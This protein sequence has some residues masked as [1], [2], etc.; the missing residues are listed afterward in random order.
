M[1][2]L[3]KKFLYSAF[4][5][6]PSYKGAATHI[7]Q[8][9]L[10]NLDINQNGILTVLGNEKLPIYQNENNLEIYRFLS[11]E[12]NYLLRAQDFSKFV[13]NI[14][15]KNSEINYFH[16]R[17][18]WSGLG[19]FFSEKKIP[20]LFEVN[21]LPSIELPF[22]YKQISRSTIKKII[23]LENVCLENSD[24]IITPSQTTKNYL[25]DKRNIPQ[26][27]ITVIS[28]GAIEFPKFDKPDDINEPYIVY[29]GALQNWQ[30]VDT[31]IYA[32]EH[33][34][35]F[36]I[37][38]LIISSEPESRSTYLKKISVRLG[39]DHK[40]IWKYQ[41]SKESLNRYLQHALISIVPLKEDERNIIQGANPLKILESMAA[42][43]P[44]V[45]SDLPIVKEILKDSLTAKLVRPE[46]PLDLSRGIR[47]VLENPNFSKKISKNA[48]LTFKKKFEWELKKKQLIEIN[49]HLM[50]IDNS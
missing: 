18:I 17:D 49:H 4:D 31:L 34:K 39:L 21:S 9:L 33:L 2:N 30:G 45:A 50:K 20:S 28:N 42:S 6:Y 38:L 46:R 7:H 27:K 32:L 8:F 3:K 43:V 36:D 19:L 41:L 12:S 29:F 26:N 10:A 44:I 16:F 22:K 35:D 1:N 11:N 25:I 48:Y 15:I 5:I 14:L 40:I 23:Y 13:N 24:I 47:F 37:K